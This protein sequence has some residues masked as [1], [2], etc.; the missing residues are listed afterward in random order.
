MIKSSKSPIDTYNL[1]KFAKHH[2]IVVKSNIQF[3][4]VSLDL[5]SVIK[6]NQVLKGYPGMQY[7]ILESW[8]KKLFDIQNKGYSQDIGYN[9]GVIADVKVSNVLENPAS[10]LVLTKFEEAFSDATF[11]FVENQ[12][13]I[14]ALSSTLMKNSKEVRL[15]ALRLLLKFT[16]LD[17]ETNTNPEI[18]VSDTFQ[19][20]CLALPLL[21][22]F[23]KTEIGFEF[24]KNKEMQLRRLEVIIKCGVMPKLYQE[25]IYNFLIG[26]LWIKFAPTQQAV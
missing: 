4:E 9:T 20:P 17:F 1:T 23:E 6:E 11:T 15:C 18:E 21:Y 2:K 10:I 25:V 7:G 14:D 5:S 19:G 13:L 3:K 26:S 16:P 24:E 8:I 12:N 22:D